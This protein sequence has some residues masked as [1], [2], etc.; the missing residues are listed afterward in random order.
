MNSGV[1]TANRIS[2]DLC[3]RMNGLAF[4]IAKNPEEL[5]R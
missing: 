3:R 4:W 2:R 1:Y 5:M